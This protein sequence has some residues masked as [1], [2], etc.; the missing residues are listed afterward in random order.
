MHAELRVMATAAREA[1]YLQSVVH[2]GTTIHRSSWYVFLTLATH[3]PVLV[4]LPCQVILLR[5]CLHSAQGQYLN[6]KQRFVFGHHLEGV[7]IAPAQ[8]AHVDM[9]ILV[10]PPQ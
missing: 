3:P 7:M 5:N 8:Q 1:L 9:H 10:N 4:L 2:F 6:A